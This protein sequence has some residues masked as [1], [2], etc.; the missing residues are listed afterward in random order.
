MKNLA[1]S[2]WGPIRPP[3]PTLLATQREDWKRYASCR[4]TCGGRQSGPFLASPVPLFSLRFRLS[5]SILDAHAFACDTTPHGLP[6]CR[7]S[8]V[9]ALLIRASHMQ[10][11]HT[12]G[13][14]SIIII[15]ISP[16]ITSLSAQ[17][18]LLR[19]GES[20]H[21]LPP[22]ANNDCTLQCAGG[23]RSKQAHSLTN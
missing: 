9:I 2:A 1:W 18:S 10:V 16:S 15:I 23:S 17:P 20:T 4:V 5:L 14:L 22:H 12:A 21:L 13:L 6:A 11:A 7:E 19:R 8:A 3:T